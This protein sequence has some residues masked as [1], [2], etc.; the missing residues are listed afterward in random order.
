MLSAEEKSKFFPLLTCSS[1]KVIYMTWRR[2]RE[3][4]GKNK[5]IKVTSNSSPHVSTLE[6]FFPFTL[7]L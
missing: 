1:L 7:P 6:N 3:K 2:K 4:G 5:K